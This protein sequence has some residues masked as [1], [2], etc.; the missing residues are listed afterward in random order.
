M[1]RAYF[2]KSAAEHG[3]EYADAEMM[4]VI[5]IP[6][7]ITYRACQSSHCKNT[8]TLF[9]MFVKFIKCDLFRQHIFNID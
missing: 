8:I 7:A 9:F 4:I 1:K 3:K 6:K 2:P 5:V